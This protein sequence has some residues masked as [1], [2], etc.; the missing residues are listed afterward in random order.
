MQINDIIVL[1]VGNK[2]SE[3]TIVEICNQAKKE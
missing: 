1:G 2:V 3:K